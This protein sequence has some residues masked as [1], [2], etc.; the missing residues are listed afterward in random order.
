M[1]SDGLSCQ[2]N[3]IVCRFTKYAYCCCEGI[4]LPLIGYD[5]PKLVGPVLADSVVE[6]PLTKR[7]FLGQKILLSRR[8][9]AG[10]GNLEYELY[11]MAQL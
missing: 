1:K 11:C 5:V 6:S 8:S 2:N 3:W 7:G 9:Y 10:I 4:K